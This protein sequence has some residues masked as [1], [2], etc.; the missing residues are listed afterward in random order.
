MVP[1]SSDKPLLRFAGAWVEVDE[2]LLLTAK[3]LLTRVHASLHQHAGLAWPTGSH[4]VTAA[5]VATAALAAAEASAALPPLTAA[6][7]D[8]L[9]AALEQLAGT[10]PQEARAVEGASTGEPGPANGAF[11][12]ELGAIPSLNLCCGACWFQ[13]KMLSNELHIV[14]AV[15]RMRLLWGRAVQWRCAPSCKTYF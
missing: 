3:E 8:A 7:R 14:Q 12:M 13:S 9:H 4:A 2:Q 11:C 15:L 1:A 5:A 10:L 6:Q